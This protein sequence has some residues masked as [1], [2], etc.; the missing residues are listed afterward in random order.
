MHRVFYL[1]PNRLTLRYKA[2][3]M[4]VDQGLELFIRNIRYA[5][6]H[7]HYDKTLEVKKFAKS[8][9]SGKDQQEEVWR[10]RKNEDQAQK[11]QRYRLYNPLTRYVVNRPRKYFQAVERLENAANLVLQAGDDNR[12]TQLANDYEKFYQGQS[13]FKYVA[14]TAEVHQVNDP[15][16]WIIAER[17][18]T[19]TSEG[20]IQ[21]TRIYPLVVGCEN[22]LNFERKYGELQW[23]LINLWSMEKRVENGAVKDIKLDGFHFYFPG[24]TLRMR[25][26]GP[27]TQS[28]DGERAVLIRSL[29]SDENWQW[30]SPDQ[31]MDL[32][33]I[34]GNGSLTDRYFYFKAF[35]TGSEEVLAS[36]MGAYPDEETDGQTLVPWFW[37]GKHVLQDIIKNKSFLDTLQVVH[38][39]AKR[40]EY[41]RTCKFVDPDRFECVGG[42]LRRGS[43]VK[44][45]CG[46]CK[47]TG[48]ELYVSD[49]DVV[50]LAMPEKLRQDESLVDLA[51]LSF[52]ENF[53]MDL[54]EFQ[55]KLLEKDVERFDNAIFNAGIVQQAQASLEETATKTRYRYSDID[56]TVM[57]YK[58]KVAQLVELFYRAG[59]QYREIPEATVDF[60]LPEDSNLAGLD[61]LLAQ[62]D[63]MNKTGVG[64]DIRRIL[65][66][67]IIRKQNE[68][69]PAEVA[70]IM[71]RMDWMPFSDKSEVERASILLSRSPEDFDRVLYE[72]HQ[73]IFREINIEEPDFE[74]MA[75]FRQ[76]SVVEG[77]VQQFRERIALAG[78]QVEEDF[79]VETS[80]E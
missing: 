43:E 58:S 35:E 21:N 38:V 6:R 45:P 13:L 65:L 32:G 23:L 68:D 15:N 3:V 27:E 69:N 53:P 61:E 44:G 59:F 75:Y 41:T 18:D 40:R 46:A 42:Q 29:Q 60:R 11:D 9:V 37:P 8:V 77:K 34:F 80:E 48:A 24:Y 52:T 79:E 12:R 20:A 10:Y 50:R 14:K 1:P 33:G 72:N 30:V 51:K 4:T 55:L 74:L 66:E 67:K 64:Y 2:H 73:A 56:S 16:A 19:R 70:W 26:I 47:G 31:K 7:E 62:L 49:Q 39:F 36:P 28:E 71:A 5:I 63:E 54:P 78:Q 17:Y 76:K 25:E 22:V 57:P